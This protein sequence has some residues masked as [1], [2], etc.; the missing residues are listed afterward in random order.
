LCIKS[1]ADNKL[2]SKPEWLK[3]KICLNSSNIN[4]VRS[5]LI[6][7]NLHT[8]CQSAKCPNIFECF[9]RKTATFM[10]MGN[11]CTRNCA[12]CGIEK[13]K[14]LL[15]D[16]KEPE[17][18]A[19]AALNM[20]LDYVVLTSVTRDDLEDGGAKHF[21]R[22]VREIKKVMLE[23]RVECLIPDLKGSLKNLEILLYSGPDVLNHNMETVE[24][25]YRLIRKSADYKRSINI[26]K[27]SK[28]IIPDIL[29]KSGFMLGLGE[30]REEIY[31]LL[32]DLKNADC[33]IITIGQYL[34]PGPKNFPVQKYYSPEEFEEIKREA[35]NFNFK[36]VISGV[37]VRSSYNAAKVFSEIKR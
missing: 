37:F 30:G 31:Q 18:T 14:P 24:R 4:D 8:V 5:L 13:G 16:N 7:L 2:V 17:N 15:L 23:S 29:T 25:N 26:L 19:K 36:S 33:D 1:L 22:T 35:E 21:G 11:I 20:G 28:I 3:K 10:L 32:F 12:F 34:S 9:S 27:N 6:G